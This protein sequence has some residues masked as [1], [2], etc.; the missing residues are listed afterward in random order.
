MLMIDCLVLSDVCCYRTTKPVRRDVD[1]QLTDVC[2]GDPI[3]VHDD[4]DVMRGWGDLDG[5]AYRLTN[6]TWDILVPKRIFDRF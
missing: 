4:G 3:S 6:G 2:Y 5:P 1:G